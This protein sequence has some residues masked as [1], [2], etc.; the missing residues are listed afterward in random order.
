MLLTYLLCRCPVHGQTEGLTGC[1]EALV[2]SHIC[3]SPLTSFSQ[4][5]YFELDRLGWG[6]SWACEGDW[7]PDLVVQQWSTCYQLS[8]SENLCCCATMKCFLRPG[9]FSYD[10]NWQGYTVVLVTEKLT[11]PDWC[12]RTDGRAV[13]RPWRDR[14]Q[15][16]SLTVR[17]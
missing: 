12:R 11:P 7:S 4:S 13:I 16:S 15:V 10:A 3:V 6:G 1:A 14:H 8:S 5:D 17:D 9:D 2:R